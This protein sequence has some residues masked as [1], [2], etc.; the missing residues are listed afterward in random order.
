MGRDKATLRIGEHTLLEGILDVMG[1]LFDEVIVVGRPVASSP[2]TRHAS[3][4]T[5]HVPDAIPGSG[6]LGPASTPM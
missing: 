1:A 6:P 4:V 2:V 5:H 3:R